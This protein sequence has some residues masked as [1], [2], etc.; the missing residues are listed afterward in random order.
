MSDSVATMRLNCAVRA[1]T[2]RMA[3]SVR[4]SRSVWWSMAAPS[5]RSRRFGRARRRGMPEILPI[6][7]SLAQRLSG[8][9]ECQPDGSSREQSDE[10][11]ARSLINAIAIDEITIWFASKEFHAMCSFAPRSP[12][13]YGPLHSLMMRAPARETPMTW[14]SP[15]GTR[16][17]ISSVPGVN[18]C[19]IR[20]RR[21]KSANRMFPND[22][23]LLTP[24][25]HVHLRRQPSQGDSARECAPLL[26]PSRQHRASGVRSDRLGQR[27]TSTRVWCDSRRSVFKNRKGGRSLGAAPDTF[28]L[29]HPQPHEHF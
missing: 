28:K 7:P 18:T 11:G 14:P 20:R 4:S 13:I 1:C 6:S 5:P 8:T 22:K 17:C 16:R 21:Q 10:R 12:P 19:G 23:K 25:A 27:R 24:P 29:R 9:R 3:A 26:R 2:H 15:T